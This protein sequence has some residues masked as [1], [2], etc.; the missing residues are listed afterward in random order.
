MK[1]R[2][3]VARSAASTTTPRT[4]VARKRIPATVRS[5]L[6]EVKAGL[7]TLYGDRLRGL[8]LYGSYARGDFRPDSDVDVL[9]VLEGP[10]KPGLE[11]SRMNEIVA[12]ICLRHDLVISILPAT[13]ESFASGA[14]L[15]FRFVRREAFAL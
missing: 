15:L 5:A 6:A 11:I 2:E 13:P 1:E 12:P 7:H 9:A 8:Y 3:Y 10:L 14:E 4:R